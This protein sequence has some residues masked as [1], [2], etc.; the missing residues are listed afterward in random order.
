MG[1]KKEPAKDSAYE[2][3]VESYREEVSRAYADTTKALV[4]GAETMGSENGARYLAY[5]LDRID[6]IVTS[7][8]T[9]NPNE[10]LWFAE[11]QRHLIRII[12]NDI[13][14]GNQ[15]KTLG[16]EAV[17]GPSPNVEEGKFEP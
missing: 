6:R 14:V 11:G 9:T 4:A 8:G 10:T 5:L 12:R 15:I 7:P 1:K 3:L 17:F 2:K 13:R 16:V